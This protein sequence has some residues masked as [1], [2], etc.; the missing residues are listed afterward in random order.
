MLSVHQIAHQAARE[1]KR[2]KQRK[3][4]NTLI[5]NLKE[6]I[7]SN[8]RDEGEFFFGIYMETEELELLRSYSDELCKIGVNVFVSEIIVEI[9]SNPTNIESACQVT[10]QYAERE[11]FEGN[12]ESHPINFFIR[13]IREGWKPRF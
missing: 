5:P 10:L 12:D 8:S 11:H 4:H 1:I 7:S 6:P 2:V 3:L 9:C 13:A